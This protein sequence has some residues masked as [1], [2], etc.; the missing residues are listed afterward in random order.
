V[1]RGCVTV[2]VSVVFGAVRNCAR[3]T[4]AVLSVCSSPPSMYPNADWSRQ[5]IPS[6]MVR[7]LSASGRRNVWMSRAEKPTRRSFAVQGAVTSA[8]SSVKPFTLTDEKPSPHTYSVASD[9][10]LERRNCVSYTFRE[11]EPSQATPSHGSSEAGRSEM[12]NL[13]GDR[14][15]HIREL[16]ARCWRSKNPRHALARLRAL[17]PGKRRKGR[18]N[19]SYPVGQHS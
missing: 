13:R 2:C 4:R 14:R 1:G 17:G 5:P 3:K 9:G 10:S 7:L 19:F 12:R 8:A 16:S 15:A 18:C 11:S 6:E